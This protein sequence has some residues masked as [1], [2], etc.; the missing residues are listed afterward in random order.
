MSISRIGAAE[1]AQVQQLWQRSRYHYKNFGEEDLPLLLQ[2]EVAF[3]A[4]TDARISQTAWGFLALQA[5]ARPV[6]LPRATPD[7]AYLRAVALARGHYP[8]TAFPT[9]LEAAQR[10]LQELGGAHLFISYGEPEWLY[11]TLF[12]AGFTLAEEVQ[13]LALPYLSR[14]QPLSSPTAATVQLRA[15]DPAD[16]PQLAVLDAAVFTPLWHMG[17]RELQTLL[18][19]GRL[20]VAHAAEELI[21][22]SALTATG[23]HAHLSRLAVH[24]AWQGQGY[25][26]FL[27]ND[28]LRY[29]QHV[30]VNTMMLNT[31]V[32]NRSAQQLYRQTG[33]RPTGQVVPVLTKVIA[34]VA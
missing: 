31:Q 23:S 18:R 1:L 33:F 11:R 6:T 14:W 5:E 22:Y 15:G 8:T 32:Q 2:E 13:F 10:Y 3:L 28:A 25:G 20:Q 9:L 34:A 26:R 16:L 4:M 12:Q 7:R 30:G 17:E 29:A 24:P 19:S 27:L 21:G